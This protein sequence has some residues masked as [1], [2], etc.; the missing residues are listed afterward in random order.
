M[1]DILSVFKPISVLNKFRNITLD[2]SVFQLH[3]KVTVSILLVS[4]ILVSSKQFF[5]EPIKCMSDK[6]KL[7]GALNAY[8][9]IHGTYTLRNS[10]NRQLPLCTILAVF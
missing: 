5:G 1:A 2:N 9:W 10:I 3:S 6:E 4:A 7:T 8:C